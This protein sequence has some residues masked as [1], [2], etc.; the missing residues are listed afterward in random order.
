MDVRLADLH[1]YYL[2]D[3]AIGMHD[4][5]AHTVTDAMLHD[6]ARV[7]GDANPLHLDAGFAATTVF[8]KPIAHGLL[9]AGFV[10]AVFGTKLPGPGAVYLAQNLKFRAPVYVGDTVVTTVTV[11]SVDPEKRRVTFRCVS[12]VAG[13]PVLEG[14]ALLMVDRRP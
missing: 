10:S 6:F 4:S 7:T 3:L 8:K 2:E 13:K 5:M 1:G 14:D 11:T 12:E 9:T